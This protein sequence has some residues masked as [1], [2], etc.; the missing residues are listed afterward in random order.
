MRRT[1]FTATIIS[2]HMGR[3]KKVIL[4]YFASEVRGYYEGKGYEVVSVTKGDYRKQAVVK[5]NGGGGFRIDRPAL[6]DACELL[7]LKLPV[8]IRFNSRAGS[9]NGNYRFKGDHHD[10]ML[11]SYHSPEQ[12]SDTLWHELCHAM[13]AERAGGTLET[14]RQVH[15]EQAR[16]TYRNRPIEREAR[17]MS[18]TMKDVPLCR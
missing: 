8:K 15:R 16:Y 18:E 3:E 10:I 1:R 13:Q 11:K 14:W 5:G 12:A 6:K 7:D 17:A 4:A 9:T 2:P